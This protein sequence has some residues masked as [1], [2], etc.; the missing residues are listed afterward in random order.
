M[1]CHGDWYHYQ[2]G[3][4]LLTEK[5]FVREHEQYFWHREIIPLAPSHS[6][7]FLLFYFLIF[8]VV[9]EFE[10]KTFHLIGRHCHLSHVSSPFCSL[11]L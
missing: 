11:F 6:L 3:K 8:F 9:Q 10:L 7:I 5:Q 1:I 2:Q 4:W